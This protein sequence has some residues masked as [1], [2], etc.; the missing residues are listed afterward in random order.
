MGG[1]EPE[2]CWR[3]H[4]DQEWGACK[5]RQV[6]RLQRQHPRAMHN[7][8]RHRKAVCNLGG[9][10]K[11]IPDSWTEFDNPTQKVKPTAIQLTDGRSLVGRIQMRLGSKIYVR[12]EDGKQV[13]LNTSEIA[14]EKPVR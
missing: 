7:L 1:V 10:K 9:G 3:S 2:P 12:T 14:S 5:C 11:V 13:E 4:R 6:S 8:L